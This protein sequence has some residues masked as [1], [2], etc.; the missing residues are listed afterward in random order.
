MANFM[1]FFVVAEFVLLHLL[2]CLQLSLHL[3]D[4]Y[5]S[6][7]DLFPDYFWIIF[8]YCFVRTILTHILVVLTISFSMSAVTH[9]VDC[10]ERQM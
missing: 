10:S 2:A 8:R 6:C 5:Y 7:N 1:L 4:H 3:I 9:G